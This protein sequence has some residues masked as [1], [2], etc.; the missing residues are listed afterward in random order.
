MN[1]KNFNMLVKA[2][3][4]SRK[5][6]SAMFCIFI[7]ISFVL[8]FIT[9]SL[10]TQ[11]WHNIDSKINNHILNRELV[12][13][14]SQDVSDG[15]LQSLI[16]KIKAI[17]NVE[18]IYQMPTKLSVTDQKGNLHNIHD[19]SYVHKYYL[20]NIIYGRA[21]SE[22]E[23]GVAIVPNIIKYYNAQEG[24]IFEIHGK[25]LVGETLELQ[26][27]TGVSKEFKVVGTYDTTDPIFSGKEILVPQS[28]LLALDD[29]LI[30]STQNAYISADKSF[31]VVIDDSKNT[32]KVFSQLEKISIVYSPKLNVDADSYNMAFIILLVITSF[33]I[34]L[35]VVGFYLFL[36]SNVK[37][38]TKELALYRAIGYK[39][40]D[41]YYIIFSE[42]FFLDVISIAVSLSVSFLLIPLVINPYL[43][44]MFGNTFMEISITI[45]PIYLLVLVIGY[46][47]AAI[48]VCI[49]AVKRTEK[50]DLTVLLREQLFP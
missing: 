12:S 24:M 21:F 33:L 5:I 35:T 14:F 22:D 26:V 38:R 19:L 7:I 3:L 28:D 1:N 32:D 34:I 9:V 37:M 50:I 40:K 13:V 41:L 16:E 20:P 42:Y 44:I 29:E 17:E 48:S 15:Y 39:S 47:L 23:T 2:S 11:L 36:K 30:K 27:F 6:T 18:D 43:E 8:L 10:V 25:D 49:S 31:T 4:K 46:L 45:N